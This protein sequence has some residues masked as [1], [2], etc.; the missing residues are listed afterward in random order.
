M[1]YQKH[2]SSK[3]GGKKP[4]RNNNNKKKKKGLFLFFAKFFSY[5]KNENFYLA[6]FN[7][8]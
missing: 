3:N 1:L 5:L 8:E 2:V 6:L 7:T 4:Y